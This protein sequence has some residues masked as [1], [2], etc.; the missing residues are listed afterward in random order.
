MVCFS[1]HRLHLGNQHVNRTPWREKIWCTL[2][3]QGKKSAYLLLI[4][5]SSLSLSERI[6]EDHENLVEN[7][8]NWTRDSHNKLMFIERIEK[9]ALFKNP[10]VTVHYT[11]THT[12]TGERGQIMFLITFVAALYSAYKCWKHMLYTQTHCLCML[13]GWTAQRVNK[14]VC[15]CR[16]VG[17]RSKL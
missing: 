12:H 8:L 13:S 4:S 6:F 1:L 11:S 14:A 10:Q 3:G 7:L 9:Y 17:S 16:R 2:A 5:P 15:L